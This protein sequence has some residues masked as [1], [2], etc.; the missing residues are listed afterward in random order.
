VNAVDLAV[1]GILALSAVAA[2]VRGFTREV[3]SAAGWVG[4]ALVTLYGFGTV[5]P[6]VQSLVGQSVVADIVTGLVLFVVSL[7]VFSLIAQAV[8]NSVM[9]SRLGFLDRSLGVVF[10]LVRGAVVVVL[11]YLGLAWAV[12]PEKQPPI[13]REA[14][15]RPL[16]EAGANWA[17]SVAPPELRVG[18]QTAMDEAAR[19]ARQA[20]DAERALRAIGAQPAAN[21]PAQPGESGYKSN[22]RRDLDRLIQT[23]Q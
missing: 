8:G 19:R 17:R 4:A 14:R 20:Q 12:P 2:F 11:I 1:L 9:Q 5:R 21:P 13:L 23:N 6:I 18:G 10:G 3:L 22:E 7:I 16:V 15:T